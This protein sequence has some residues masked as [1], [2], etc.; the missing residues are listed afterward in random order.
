M[1]I[2]TILLFYLDLFGVAVFAIT[3]ALAAGRKQMDFFGVIVLAMVT[4]LGGGTIRDLVLGISPVFWASQPVYVLVA[5]L[6][7]IIIFFLVR[8][9]NIPARLILVADAIGLAIFTI[10]G[11]E[12]ALSIVGIHPGI[13]IV[14]GVM[15]GVVGGIIRDMLSGEI[16]LI[17]RREIYATASLCGAIAYICISLLLNNQILA[18]ITSIV[19]ILGLRLAAIKWNLALPLHISKEE[20]L[21]KTPKF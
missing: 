5:S 6:M 21:N 1:E 7:G 15:T 20:R 8:F 4:A 18:I 17:L 9:Y 12:R 16:P 19:I 10:I 11:A 13:A 2:L 3:G 14:M